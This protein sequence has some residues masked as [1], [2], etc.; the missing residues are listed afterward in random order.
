MLG[1][2]GERTQELFVGMK[3]GDQYYN[4]DKAIRNGMKISV[5]KKGSYNE[6]S[7]VQCKDSSFGKVLK[8]IVCPDTQADYVVVKKMDSSR[9]ENCVSIN[10]VRGVRNGIYITHLKHLKWRAV[11]IAVDDNDEYFIPIPLNHYALNL[12]C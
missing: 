1:D 10:K 6:D 12:H 8:V 5:A 2:R 4:Y 3:P 11:R 9:Q 7:Y